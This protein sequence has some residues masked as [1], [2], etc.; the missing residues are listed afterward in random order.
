MKKTLIVFSSL[1]VLLSACDK[2]N[3]KNTSTTYTINA[4]M[5]GS[6]EVPAVSTSGTGNVTGTYDAATNTL[7]YSVTWSGLTTAATMAH[8]HGPAAAGTNAAVIVPFTINANGTSANGTTTLTDAQETDMLA[9]KWYSNVHTSTNPGG[10]IR[11]QVT[12]TQ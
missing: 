1:L 12:A 2:N 7:T 9:G 11:G 5:A 8:F 4:S 10:E 3:N 6:Q